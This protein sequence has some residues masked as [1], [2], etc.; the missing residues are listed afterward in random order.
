MGQSRPA[1]RPGRQRPGRS[2]A[3]WKSWC[4]ICSAPILATQIW[5]AYSTRRTW[6]KCFRQANTRTRSSAIPPGRRE[7]GTVT[8]SSVA[9]LRLA[10]Q[11]GSYVAA[12]RPAATVTHPPRSAADVAAAL[13]ANDDPVTWKADSP[14]N[15]ERVS[16]LIEHHETAPRRILADSRTSDRSLFARHEAADSLT[17]LAYSIEGLADDDADEELR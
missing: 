7:I 17:P 5:T 16:S 13:G 4:A 12:A 1:G 2:E 15:L 6:F 8:G 11:A 9:G 14:S 3:T 10:F